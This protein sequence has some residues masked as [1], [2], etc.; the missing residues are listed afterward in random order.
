MPNF[1]TFS[2]SIFHV[3]NSFHMFWA[4][5]V[6][7]IHEFYVSTVRFCALILEILTQRNKVRAIASGRRGD[8]RHA[9]LAAGRRVGGDPQPGRALAL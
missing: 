8:G 3:L 5:V 6:P 2:C 4:L 1:G 7:R 9:V